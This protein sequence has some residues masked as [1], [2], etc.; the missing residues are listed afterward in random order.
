[1]PLIATCIVPSGRAK[2]VSVPLTP[3]PVVER[4]GRGDGER[5]PGL[6]AGVRAGGR[7]RRVGREFVERLAVVAC[8]VGADGAVGDGDGV[9]LAT[10][11]RGC[12]R[13]RGGRGGGSARCRAGPAAAAGCDEQEHCA[14]RGDGTDPGSGSDDSHGDL[15]WIG[16]RRT[17]RVTYVGRVRLV[18]DRGRHFAP[19]CAIIP[20]PC[21][22]G[23]LGRG[24]A[25][26]GS[27]HRSG[28]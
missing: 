3:V 14:D 1:M 18:S 2:V 25:Q 22:T 19:S 23:T 20:E 11:R 26:L 7:V 9:R 24:V 17:C 13:W 8:Q 6:C 16:S 27:A 28:R 5:R 4:I 12:G 15:L 21:S 10:A